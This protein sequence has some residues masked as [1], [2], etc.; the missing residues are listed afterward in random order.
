MNFRIH[1]NFIFCIFSVDSADTIQFHMWN[2]IFLNG[3][4]TVCHH[5]LRGKFSNLFRGCRDNKL[6][7]DEM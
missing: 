1:L 5:F 3:G 4:N 2:E 6:T 7:T